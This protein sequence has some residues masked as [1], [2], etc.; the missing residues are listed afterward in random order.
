MRRILF[1][2]FLLLLLTPTLILAQ[3]DSVR[4]VFLDAESWFLFEEYTEALPLYESLLK[5]DP[6][7]DMLKYKIGICLLNDPYQKDKAIQYLLDASH[8]I[9]PSY[10][11]NSL[12]E[13][14]A[15][16]DVLYYLGNAYLVNELL[17][18]AIE[19]YEEFLEVMD[20]DVYDEELV[21][22]Q[23]RSCRNAQRLLTMPAD[24]DLLLIDSLVN[25]RYSDIHPVV[26]GD[27]TKLAFVTKLPFFD[28]AF[29][30][31]KTEDGWSYPQM[32][33]QMLGFDKDVYPVALSY[34]GT[35][36]IL[37][38]DDNYIG[39]LYH[40]RMEDGLW[41]PATKMGEHISTKYWESHACF[42][43]DG[44]TLYFTSNRKG[45]HGGL[46]IYLSEK[47]TD[48]KWGPPVNLGTTINTRYNEECPYISE[49]GQTLF[50]SSY[51]HYNMGGYDI[52]Y[53]K[54][55]ADGTWAEP[56]NIGYP[57]NTT[58]D[59]LYFQPIH[60]GNAAY[61]SI[62]HPS[63]IGRH[64]IYYM[65]I[66]SVNNPRLYYVSGNLRTED[67]SIDSTQMT[68]Y[69]IDTDSGDTLAYTS[70]TE[71][72]A[73]AFQ[74]KHGIYELHFT[75][76][77]YEDLIKPLQITDESNKQ[78]IA[79]ED[80]MVL[81]LVKEEAEE[82]PEVFEGEESQIKLKETQFE[83]VAGVALMVP[84][85]APKGSTLVVRT[86]QDSVLISTDTLVTEKRKTDLQIIPL[87]GSSRIELELTDKEGNI[88]RN[89][90]M[91]VGIALAA[92]AIEE[93]VM[94]EQILQEGLHV[95]ESG[96]D[97]PPHGVPVGIMLLDLQDASEGSVHDI[98]ME[99]DPEHEG[100]DSQQ[101]LFDYLYE[102]AEAQGI[103]PEEIDLLLGLTLVGEDAE[104]LLQQ[105]IEQ[106]SGP[107]KAY[108]EELD[109]EAEG[110]ESN[111]D[112][113]KHLE[114]VAE[115]EGFTMEEV[116]E[117]MVGSLDEDEL[118]ALIS[119][120]QHKS[121]GN[122]HAELVRLDSL[123]AEDEG[124]NSKKE[125]FTYLYEQADNQGYS[126][127][128]VDQLLV[129][130]LAGDDAGL[131][132][133][134]LREQAEGPLKAYLEELDLEAEGIES[135][136]DLLKHLEQ[137]AEAE[138]F[139]ME[140]VRK[141]MM[142]SL[143]TPLEVDR[144]Y[145][146]LLQSSDGMVREILESLNL[147]EE[148]IYTVEELIDL[149]SRELEE[150]GLSKKERKQILNEL[151]GEAYGGS[152]SSRDRSA[153]PVLVLLAVA[154]AGIVWFIIAWWRR[155]EKEGKQRE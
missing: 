108:L 62:Y 113:L 136:E 79:L 152:E 8:N 128:E 49:D 124:I 130:T 77:G 67:G 117:A 43:K 47:Q 32:I 97:H 27:G 109:L 30:T 16:T 118:G 2:S 138:G 10:K 155:R 126:I 76:E 52:F 5:S 17:E 140:Q 145:E 3:R 28:G 6:G 133:Q 154:G 147:R 78:G 72:G 139:T 1:S 85:I 127:E 59:N 71:E 90:L 132:L 55:N 13:R 96:L 66:Y 84:V 20:H 104:L 114:K 35:E 134:Q 68:V 150:R 81:S 23:I 87:P 146:E 26:S 64:D 103:E 18:R 151:F 98:L 101:E 99:L 86:Y 57:I 63:G 54:K 61:Y 91:V 142:D 11:E 88:H 94:E 9:N 82:E 135:S 56:V 33:T 129:G 69:V 12:K 112:L 31:E 70:P 141:A 148:G 51:G 143:E 36:M 45:T 58:D 105:L 50:F 65:N 73:F 75:G 116:R 29:F 131:L 92:E 89:S 39:N 25:T 107:L 137:V 48:G 21:L 22:A 122:L 100:I 14:T 95:Q 106:A 34:D 111:E 4:N 120:L 93:D 40:S 44:Q 102:Q 83:E 121:T 74:L 80:N 24:I 37:Y 119:E 41:L 19:S 53:S 153:W 115:A 46:D 123:D 7:N 38:Y 125:L 110:I 60:K 144:L 149:I 42:S 15:P